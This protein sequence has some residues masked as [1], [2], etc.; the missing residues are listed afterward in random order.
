VATNRANFA[1][2]A[3]RAA[4]WLASESVAQTPALYSMQDVLGLS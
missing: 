4:C 3:V 2:G 1:T